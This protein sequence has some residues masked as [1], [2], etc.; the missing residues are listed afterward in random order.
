MLIDGK[1]V[2]VLE[3]PYREVAYLRAENEKL[4][5]EVTEQARLLGISAEKELTLLSKIEMLERELAGV[6]QDAERYRWLRDSSVGPSQ[7][8]ELLS[9]DCHPPIMTLKCMFELDA[10]IDAA[11]KGK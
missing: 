3:T 5:E 4:T 1:P 2:E 9:D 6:K 11:M 10:A 7:I 8:W